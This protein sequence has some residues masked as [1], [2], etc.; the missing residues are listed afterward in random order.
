MSRTHRRGQRSLN[1]RKYLKKGVIWSENDGFHSYKTGEFVPYWYDHN[2]PS[3][4]HKD[5]VKAEVRDHHREKVSKG[6]PRWIRKVDIAN[7]TR[8]HKL[9]ISEAMKSRDYDVVL[10]GLDKM[11]LMCRMD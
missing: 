1:L 3:R 2:Y 8:S 4:S 11:F 7:Q 5:Y 9:A 6:I 10:E